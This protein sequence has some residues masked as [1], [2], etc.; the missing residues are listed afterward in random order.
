MTPKNIHSFLRKSFISATTT[1]VALFSIFAA[2]HA[3]ASRASSKLGTCEYYDSLS[4]ELN[5]H[6]DGYLL[7][8]GAHYCRAFEKNI[9]RFSASGNQVLSVIRNCL[10]EE[11]EK[12]PDLTCEN[13][14]S[15]AA[16]SHVPCYRE[17]KFCDMNLWD[18]F[19]LME[20]VAP[21]LMDP[22]LRAAV[23]RIE[24]ECLREQ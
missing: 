10:Q 17:A 6:D 19:V 13:V 22:D 21:A 24:K 23:K 5:C 3:E 16:Q 9:E 15:V 1:I 12:A 8:F 11:L 2:P 20:I 7:K 18:Q 14:K 4:S